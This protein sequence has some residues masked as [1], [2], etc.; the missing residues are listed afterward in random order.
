MEDLNSQT[1]SALPASTTTLIAPAS[2]APVAE[3]LT[4]TP[5]GTTLIDG[6][7]VL[8]SDPSLSQALASTP[9]LLLC[10]GPRRPGRLPGRPRP[11][12][13]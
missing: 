12:G 8:L 4:Y 3:D 10:L 11:A 2:A 7:V 5:S 9:R 1:L 6:R 13:L